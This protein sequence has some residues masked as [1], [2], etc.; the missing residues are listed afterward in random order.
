MM[1]PQ[2]TPFL[3]IKKVRGGLRL[4]YIDTQ[5]SWIPPGVYEVLAGD[6]W[7]KLEAAQPHLSTS[8][9][10]VRAVDF[11]GAKTE[12]LLRLEEYLL[13]DR[14]S[15]QMRSEQGESF[16]VSFR[17]TDVKSSFY[18]SGNFLT[19]IKWDGM[20]L[21]WRIVLPEDK[22]FMGTGYQATPHAGEPQ[23]A[24]SDLSL[25]ARLDITRAIAAG[26]NVL[27]ENI[28]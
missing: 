18:V 26:E 7:I 1:M 6:E 10:L 13:A 9:Q 28:P 4:Y 25:A 22:E 3:V 27:V 11:Y 23:V 21:L 16:T 17:K 12:A 15:F 2:G 19:E 5:K 24:I 14:S 20:P 8:A